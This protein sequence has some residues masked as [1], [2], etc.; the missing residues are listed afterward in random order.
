MWS[1]LFSNFVITWL[2]DFRYDNTVF[3]HQIVSTTIIA[4]NV[5]CLHTYLQLFLPIEV[6]ANPQYIH[7]VNPRRLRHFPWPVLLPSFVLVWVPISLVVCQL[8]QVLVVLLRN[9]L[10]SGRDVLSIKEKKEKVTWMEP[11][12]TVNEGQQKKRDNPCTFT[13]LV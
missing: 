3:P 9:L 2:D 6:P 8:S 5:P 12:T 13:L 7:N 1:L 11:S 10:I 4:S